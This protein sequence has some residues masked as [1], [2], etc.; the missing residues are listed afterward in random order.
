MSLTKE[1]KVTLNQRVRDLVAGTQKHPM[2][3][4]VTLAGS[5]YTQQTLVQALQGVVDVLAASDT[6]KASW[7]ES[8]KNVKDTKTKTLPLVSSY[9]SWIAATYG[10]APSALADFGMTPRK[11]PTPLTAEQK[12][13]AAAKRKATRVARNTL[14]KT[15]KKNIKGNVTG[16]V[17]TPTTSTPNNVAAPTT[18]APP[19]AVPVTSAAAPAAGAAATPHA[20]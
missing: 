12:A 18:S 13:A 15:Q 7:K 16:I 5:S 4:S 20:A 17:V 10:S 1:T 8:L 19:A 14:G 6:A 11:V 2:S 9:R 3:G